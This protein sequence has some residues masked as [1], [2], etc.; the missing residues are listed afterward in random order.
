MAW[1]FNLPDGQ[2]AYMMNLGDT[3]VPVAGYMAELIGL[4]NDNGMTGGLVNNNNGTFTNTL[5]GTPNSILG[6]TGFDWSNALGWAN[7]GLDAIGKLGNL[8][9]GLQQLKLAKQQLALQK[10]A[11]NFNKNATTTNFNN[12]V[13]AQQDAYRR[14]GEAR[15]SQEGLSGNALNQAVADRQNGLQLR[16]L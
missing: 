13:N 11:F 15:Y 3:T 7:V 5:A 2:Q 9:G 16:T 10:D 12:S 14:Q 1:N 4:S 8:W 6:S